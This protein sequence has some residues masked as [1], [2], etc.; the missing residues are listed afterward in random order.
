MDKFV[1]REG[2]KKSTTHEDI[3]ALPTL[4]LTSTSVKN[5]TEKKTQFVGRKYDENFIKFGFCVYY[6]EHNHNLVQPQ[7]V[8]CGEL[9]A[10]ESLKPSKL[11]RHLET[12]HPNLKE[13]PIDYFELLKDD[14]HKNQ[15]VKKKYSSVSQY[16]LK[17]SFLVSYRIS[18][19][20]NRILS[21]KN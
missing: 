5:S 2:G 17:A 9:L 4:S 13:K 8:V 11:K 10:N 12:K 1:I 20:L 21:G 7:C 14:L 16:A 6:S 15:K 18:K 19:C 3:T